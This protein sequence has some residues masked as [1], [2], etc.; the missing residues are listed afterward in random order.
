MLI[1]KEYGQI[2]MGQPGL[3]DERKIVT[4]ITI[5]GGHGHR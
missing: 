5:V 3:S 4:M 2:K 1:M